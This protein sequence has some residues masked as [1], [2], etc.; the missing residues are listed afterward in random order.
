MHAL[1][2]KN[3]YCFWTAP[4]LSA[5]I[6]TQG[7]PNEGQNY[8]LTCAVIGDEMLAPTNRTYRWDNES[9]MSV[10]HTATLNIT[11]LYPAD[12]G[13]YTCTTSFDSP[14]LNTTRSLNMTVEVTVNRKWKSNIL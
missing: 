4:Q 7:D 10:D 12:A 13:V 3:I 8:S 5:T 9:E 1:Q 14:Y 6:T 11:P 2:R